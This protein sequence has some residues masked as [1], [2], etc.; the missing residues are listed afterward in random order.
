MT[1]FPGGGALDLSRAWIKGLL[2][3]D[4]MLSVTARRGLN[5]TR[6]ADRSLPQQPPSQN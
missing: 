1:P 3:C 5:F 4:R 2:G 6:G